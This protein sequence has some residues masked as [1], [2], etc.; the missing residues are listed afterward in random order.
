MP[1]RVIRAF[2]LPVLFLFAMTSCDVLGLKNSSGNNSNNTTFS[3]AIKSN[4]SD[5]FA[6]STFVKVYCQD[7]WTVSLDFGENIEVEGENEPFTPWAQLSVPG[8]KGV[9]TN[10]V[11]SYSKNLS[12]LQRVVTV[13]LKS[14]GKTTSATFTQKGA[15]SILDGKDYSSEKSDRKWLELPE[16]K[17]NDGLVWGCHFFTDDNGKVKR[18]YSFYYSDSKYI[19]LWVAYPLNSS[20]IS[21]GQRS[22]AWSPDPLFPEINQSY[23]W[24][25]AYGSNDFDRG[26]QLP[27]ASRYAGNSNPQTFYPTNITPQ[28]SSFNQGLWEKFEETVRRW[29]TASAVDTLYVVSGCQF[30]T[31]TI[32]D[33]G[34]RKVNIPAAYWKAC[35]RREKGDNPNWS[36]CGVWVDHKTN[37]TSVLSSDRMSISRLEEIIG[38][39]LFVNL[40]EIVGGDAIAN[41]IETR[42]PSSDIWSL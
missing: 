35:L 6:G 27:S 29:A 28:R 3:I 42:T 9:T 39:N 32:T 17:A 4:N 2:I 36:A 26:H 7:D 16:T 23:I 8:G 10:V 22:N 40:P 5:A 18:N 19:S 34:S 12:L 14:N 30:G 11:L 33:R 20:L 41:E 21:K 31:E 25:G 37:N 38:V 24:N 15:G 1:Y 13:V